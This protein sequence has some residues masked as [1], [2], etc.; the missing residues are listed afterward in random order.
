MEYIDLIDKNGNLRN[1]TAERKEIHKNGLLHHASGLIIVRKLNGGGG[2]QLLSQQRSFKK[3]KN[4]GLWDMSASGHVPS[5]ES[6]L[7]SLIR[8]VDEELG[9]SIKPEKLKLL[10]K[11]W[12]NEIYSPSFIEN[13]LDYIYVTE[14]NVD[15]NNI[16]IQK[17]EVERVAWINTD[18]FKN[19][20]RERRAVNR[21]GVWDELFKYLENSAHNKINKNS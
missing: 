20:L 2:Y 6:P 9:L 8:E 18:E 1:E 15:I 11:F 10:G 4:A 5:G 14:L 7:D 12:R 17:E 13:E 21:K 19:M 3:D 16:S